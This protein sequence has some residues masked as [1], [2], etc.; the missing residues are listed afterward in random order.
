LFIIQ[1]VEEYKNEPR[2]PKSN[3]PKEAKEDSQLCSN[4]Y[5]KAAPTH[6]AKKFQGSRSWIHKGASRPGSPEMPPV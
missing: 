2:K 5:A 1:V 3:K 4:R 6:P